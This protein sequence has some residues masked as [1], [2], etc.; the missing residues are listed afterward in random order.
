MKREREEVRANFLNI[1][2]IKFTQINNCFNIAVDSILLSYFA[3]IN[4]KI[5]KVIE[6]GCGTGIVSMLIASRSK[7][8]VTGIELQKITADIAKKNIDESGLN[9]R[10][11]IINSDIKNLK[12]IFEQ[13]SFDMVLS[14]PPFFK[15]DGNKKQ[16]NKLEELKVARHEIEITLEQIVVQG[17]YLL[18]NGGHF[19]MVHRSE[20]T[21]EIMAVFQKYRIEPKRVCFCYT[22]ENSDAKI[23][24]I[25]GV[26]NV[27]PGIKIMQPVYI[28]NRDGSY[29]EFYM[30]LLNGENSFDKL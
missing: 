27:K 16:I 2:G 28:N 3:T 21:A 7:C 23:V 15:N 5:K 20:R 10:I 14:N 22:K 30:R 9:N 8:E 4:M 19:V 13:Q 24:L 25:E 12:T 26:K 11:K 1:K 17:S 18:K 29:T 6:L